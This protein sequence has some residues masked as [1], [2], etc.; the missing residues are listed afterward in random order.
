MKKEE[1]IPTVTIG[2]PKIIWQQTNWPT[3]K[4]LGSSTFD[5]TQFQE[6]GL[7]FPNNTLVTYS[8]GCAKKNRIVKSISFSV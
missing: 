4:C 2:T 1:W 3:I 5:V 8:A 6:Y 7:I